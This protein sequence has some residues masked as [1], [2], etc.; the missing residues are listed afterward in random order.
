MEIRTAE[1]TDADAVRRVHRASIEGFGP[2]AYDPEQV[3]AWAS[4]CESADYATPI[5]S[6]DVYFAVAERGGEVVG[7]GSLRLEATGDCERTTDAEVTA[8]YVHP[9]V[10]REGIGTELLADLER[11]ARERG[12]P[13]L[14]LSSSL[15]A[16]PF[17]EH[18][19][20]ERVRTRT[21]EFSG[22]RST[23]VEGR[24]VEM[25]KELRDQ[26]G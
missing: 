20:Y 18:H 3:E 19:G 16:V 13:R 12:R 1:P 8:V 6:D 25:R 14:R 9:E 21:H 23:G 2:A 10:A 5:S 22:H 11:E 17:Y 7:F 26:E 4:G 15:N 24:V